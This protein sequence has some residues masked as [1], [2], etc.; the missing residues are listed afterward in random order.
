[1]GLGGIQCASLPLSSLKKKG[2]RDFK[3]RLMKLRERM[4]SMFRATIYEQLSVEIPAGATV[5]DINSE[6]M[7]LHRF[8]KPDPGISVDLRGD[9]ADHDHSD[10]PRRFP[11]NLS[12]Q[13]PL[14]SPDYIIAN[15]VLEKVNDLDATLDII[16]NWSSSGTRLLIFSYSRLWLPIVRTL[17]ILGLKE[18]NP[19]GNYVSWRDLQNLLEL[20]GFETC[21][22]RPAVL[23]P[24]RVPV[25][26]FF[27]NRVLAMQPILRFFAFG[28]LVVARKTAV[29]S[30]PQM[31]TVSVVV[32]AR[33][34]KGNIEAI[35][36]RVP[37]FDG[38]L[39]LIFVEGHSKDGTWE[40]I[41]R[42]VGEPRLGRPA[43]RAFKQKG[44]G[45]ADAVWLGFEEAKGDLLVILDADMGVDPADLEKFISPIRSGFCE[46]T[47]GTRMV[48]RRE[49]GAMRLLNLAGNKL[50]AHVMFLLTGYRLSDS[51]CGTKV[52]SADNF[53]RFRTAR[54][55]VVRDPFGDFDLLFGASSLNL[56]V[57][58]VPVHYQ[59]RSYGTTNISRFRDGFRLV[60][61]VLGEVLRWFTVSR[62]RSESRQR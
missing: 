58:E 13:A 12:P 7:L 17:E 48:Y 62:L 61:V 20:H 42:F 45:K 32:P 10:S 41:Q 43:V 21:K 19:E 16:G 54:E 6:R 5:V 8:L 31:M 55:P 39:E 46:F 57:R 51:L 27:V 35:I 33:N 3:M 49:K 47:N 59:A 25:L 22:T 30:P 56:S 9:L 4:R 11:S 37:R 28:R 23:M 44:Q 50:F 52:I 1:M 15:F 36:E 29:T 18:R 53:R 60:A 26:S 40:E 34:E 2:S 24:F 38:L 14:P